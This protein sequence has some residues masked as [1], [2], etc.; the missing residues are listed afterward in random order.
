VFFSWRGEVED[1]GETGC[2]ADQQPH[3]GEVEKGG[4][5]RLGKQVRNFQV[6]GEGQWRF[7]KERADRMGMA[8]RPIQVEAMAAPFQTFCHGLGGT[9]IRGEVGGKQGETE[10]SNEMIRRFRGRERP[11]AGRRRRQSD[12]QAEKRSQDQESRGRGLGASQK[13]EP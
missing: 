5:T 1:R 3:W 2:W 8:S 13:K 4:W 12:R 7:K 9:L 11:S 6:P 10:A